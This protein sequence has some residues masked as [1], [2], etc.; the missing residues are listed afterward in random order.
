[1]VI[2]VVNFV[3]TLLVAICRWIVPSFGEERLSYAL[4]SVSNVKAMVNNFG[5]GLVVLTLASPMF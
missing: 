1:M 5:A 3:R 2:W 4:I